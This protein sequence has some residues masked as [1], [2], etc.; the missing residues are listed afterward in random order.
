MYECILYKK[1]KDK[2]VECTACNH[3]CLILESK[4]GICGVRENK[5]GKLY[6]LVHGLVVSENIDPI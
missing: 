5:D 6:L 1:H 3:R 2:I 4:R